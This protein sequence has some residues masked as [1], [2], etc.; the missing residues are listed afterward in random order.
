MITSPT[1]NFILSLLNSLSVNLTSTISS[2]LFSLE[3][4]FSKIKADYLLENHL[5][6]SVSYLFIAKNNN[7]FVGISLFEKGAQN[8]S[9]G[10]P[11][12]TILEKEKIELKYN[13]D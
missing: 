1:P 10:M 8:Y 13:E 11:K 3:K 7:C 12:Y 5:N 4:S 6:D 9:K 2:F